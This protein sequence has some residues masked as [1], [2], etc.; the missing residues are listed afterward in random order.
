M[1]F[2]FLLLHLEMT[3]SSTMCT[4]ITK[5][6]KPKDSSDLRGQLIFL[7]KYEYIGWVI[8]SAF[9]LYGDVICI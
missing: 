6:A 3:A 9:S 2:V 7:L 8:F 1:L 5:Y 4:P